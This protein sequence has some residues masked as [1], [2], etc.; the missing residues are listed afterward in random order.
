MKLIKV[1][2]LSSIVS[3]VLAKAAFAADGHLD[4]NVNMQ[5]SDECIRPTYGTRDA[6]VRTEWPK[7]KEAPK[8]DFAPPLYFGQGQFCMTNMDCNP[9]QSCVKK[10]NAISGTCQ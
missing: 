10:E 3:L 6:C 8:S 7:K 9:K 4:F 1:I 5:E 2:I